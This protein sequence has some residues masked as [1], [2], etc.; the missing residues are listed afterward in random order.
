MMSS[1]KS[2][3]VVCFGEI[4]WDILP[5]N[6]VP[7]GAP[8][9]VAYHLRKLGIRPAL[10]SRVG[11]DNYGKKLIQLMEKQDIPTEF[12]QMDFELDTG[13]VIMTAGE[14][15]DIHF[16]IVKPVAWDN[17]QWDDHFVDLVRQSSYFIY[18]SLSVRSEV[19]RKV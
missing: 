16:D 8:M 12:F 1:E 4:L 5:N 3:P 19:S 9:N 15:D 11:L 6:I 17:I 7:G 2:Y 13:K 18:G 10:I 14:G